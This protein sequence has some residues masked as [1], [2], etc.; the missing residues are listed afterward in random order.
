MLK[1]VV[2]LNVKGLVEDGVA[3]T[4]VETPLIVPV[5]AICVSPL[6]RVTVLGKV[7]AN[8]LNY[9]IMEAGVT[10]NV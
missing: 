10:V 5:H 9:G 6:Y 4:R 8:V 7:K 2:R 1:R 3:V